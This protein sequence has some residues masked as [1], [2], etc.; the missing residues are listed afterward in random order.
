MSSFVKCQYVT[1]QICNH[2]RSSFWFWFYVWSNFHLEDIGTEFE[3]NDRA[4]PKPRFDI[5]FLSC[6]VRSKIPWQSFI[7]LF[8]TAKLC[9]LFLL[10]AVKPFPDNK[11]LVTFRQLVFATTTF[12]RKF[13][14]LWHNDGYFAFPPEWRCFTPEHCDLTIEKSQNRR[15]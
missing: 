1:L 7:L 14:A 9:S 2:Q 4:L 15:I 5:K 12:S 11:V 13:V 6:I 3:R 8:T 10:K